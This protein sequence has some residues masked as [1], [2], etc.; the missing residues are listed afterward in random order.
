MYRAKRPART[1]TASERFVWPNVT[2]KSN[3]DNKST[4]DLEN[5]STQARNAPCAPLHVQLVEQEHLKPSL[6]SCPGSVWAKGKCLHVKSGCRLFGEENV[7]RIT[8]DDVHQLGVINHPQASE[9]WI[10]IIDKPT[11]TSSDMDK[12]DDG[13]HVAVQNVV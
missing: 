1:H 10:E 2:G 6:Y 11:S 9:E 4:C 8:H 3:A 12:L 7:I 13:K 5:V